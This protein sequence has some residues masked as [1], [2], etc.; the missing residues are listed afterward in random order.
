MVRPQ[1]I[2]F[3]QLRDPVAMQQAV[4]RL[5]ENFGH[6]IK[7][8]LELLKDLRE[9]HSAMTDA[10][11]IINELRAD[12][13]EFDT[14]MLKDSFKHLLKEH[15]FKIHA[16]DVAVLR[17][18]IFAEPEEFEAKN[19]QALKNLQKNLQDLKDHFNL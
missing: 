7:G 19:E 18:E 13:M 2:E 14:L 11:K 12:I 5:S 15:E 1:D 9:K 17:R 10:K 4:E 3:I 6:G 8:G 16:P